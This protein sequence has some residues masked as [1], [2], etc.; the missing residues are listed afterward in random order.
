MPRTSTYQNATSVFVDIYI[1]GLKYDDVKVNFGPMFA[2]IY[3]ASSKI[4]LKANLPK[5]HSS[6]SYEVTPNKISLTVVKGESQNL[7]WPEPIQF[8]MIESSNTHQSDQSHEKSE[9]PKSDASTKAVGDQ[10]V[11]VQSDAQNL[12]AVKDQQAIYMKNLSIGDGVGGQVAL[13]TGSDS[14]AAKTLEMTKMI[15]NGLHGVPMMALRPSYPR[16]EH[17]CGLENE[18]V[19]CFI[20][21][22]VQCLASIPKFVDYF[23]SLQYKVDINKDNPLSNSHGAMAHAFAGLLHKL[24]TEPYAFCPNQFKHALKRFWSL[25]DPLT[26]QDAQ[27]FLNYLLDAIH[28]DVVMDIDL[29]RILKKPY[30]ELPDYDDTVPDE[31]IAAAYW[32]AHLKRN[33]SIVGKEHMDFVSVAITT[34]TLEIASC[35][36]FLRSFLAVDTFQGQYKSQI[37]CKTCNKTSIKFDAFMNL[38]MEVPSFPADFHC[39]FVRARGSRQYRNRISIPPTAATS[40][41]TNRLA[42]FYGVHPQNIQ[43][44]VANA[45][46]DSFD[47]LLLPGHIVQNFELGYDSARVAVSNVYIKYVRYSDQMGDLPG[48]PYS[49]DDDEE[50]VKEADDDDD[51]SMHEEYVRFS[52]PTVLELASG[53]YNMRELYDAIC[54]QLID[55]GWLQNV[56]LDQLLGSE[57]QL[58]DVTSNNFDS[59]IV[60]LK[61]NRTTP[62]DLVWRKEIYTGC[63]NQQ[64]CDTFLDGLQ[65]K[66]SPQAANLHDCLAQ[67]LKVEDIDEWYCSRC[68]THT[69]GTKKLDLWKLPEILIVHLKRFLLHP[70]LQVWTKLESNVSFPVDD[71]HAGEFSVCEA[72]RLKHYELFASHKTGDAIPADFAMSDTQESEISKK[73]FMKGMSKIREDKND[74]QAEDQII[75]LPGKQGRRKAADRAKVLEKEI[76]DVEKMKIG[77]ENLILFNREK[78]MDSRAMTDLEEQKIG[79]EKRIDTLMLKKHK[80]LVYIASVDGSAPPNLPTPASARSITNLSSPSSSKLS[81]TVNNS[82]PSIASQGSA[83]ERQSD[84]AV[85]SQSHASPSSIFPKDPVIARAKVLFDFEAAPSSQEMT[86]KTGEVLL[87]Y[88]KQEDGWWRCKSEST[89]RDGYVPGNYTEAL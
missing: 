47:R 12:E 27:E 75:T 18:G 52:A 77:V 76:A 3:I 84:H 85:L 21:N 62:I 31:T 19:D 29:N 80:L 24:A 34:W 39:Y 38:T 33:D 44:Y 50:Q 43:G 48:N 15:S 63:L 83:A 7:K 88:E 55:R 68:K 86:V 53:E 16:G 89:G 81:P 60:E 67:H 42:R 54:E 79:L 14:D 5:L 45:S 25:Y 35:S 4:V 10:A 1:K 49:D 30:I 11:S 57:E 32:D 41:V 51:E 13:P 36:Y 73:T 58:F 65:D 40:D 37:T 74:D 82:S 71:F 61:A 9:T 87:V 59:N 20:N 66:I 69:Q 46:R 56:T 6:A 64:A 17:F 22:I 26:Q 8:A 78:N 23:L 70:R 2:L 72:E 28:E